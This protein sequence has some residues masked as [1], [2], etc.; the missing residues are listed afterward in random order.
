MPG[1]QK[2]GRMDVAKKALKIDELS[3]RV[4][5]AVELYNGAQIKFDRGLDS[6]KEWENIIKVLNSEVKHIWSFI[7]IASHN[8]GVI[9][10][11]SE[12]LFKAKELF[13]RALEI[14]MGQ[15]KASASYIQRRLKVGYNRA[16]RLVEEMEQ[17]GIVGP[18]QGSKPREIL[19]FTKP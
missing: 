4:K 11:Q 17:R 12:D 7:A 16:A 18:A 2:I 15:G 5:I 14:V 13:E 3:D 10:A 6:L 8:M 19:H 9:H 1:E